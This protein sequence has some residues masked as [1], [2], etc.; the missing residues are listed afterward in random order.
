MNEGEKHR[1][2]Y[3]SILSSNLIWKS[4]GIPVINLTYDETLLNF[5]N[6]LIEILTIE[7]EKNDFSRDLCH[8]GIKTQQKIKNVINKELAEW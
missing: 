3:F 4:L 5:K 2:N 7:P 8:F 6:D 1:Q